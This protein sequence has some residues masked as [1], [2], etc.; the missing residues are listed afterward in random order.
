M[1]P[2]IWLAAVLL[3]I[4][5]CT[6]STL[7]DQEPTLGASK[8]AE[9]ETGSTG[10]VSGAREDARPGVNGPSALD[11]CIMRAGSFLWPL[12]MGPG[13]PP[14]GWGEAGVSYTSATAYTYFECHRLNATGLELGPARFL[15]EAHTNLPY[16]NCTANSRAFQMVPF[17]MYIEGPI[18]PV[19]V[20]EH[21][22]LEVTEVKFERDSREVG[23]AIVEVLRLAHMDGG[24]VLE[25]SYAF[26]QSQSY[27]GPEVEE[28]FW[29]HEGGIQ[30]WMLAFEAEA[31][32]PSTPV[33][34]GSFRTPTVLA[35]EGVFE[36]PL[37]TGF[38]SGISVSG[39]FRWM[40]L[41]EC[42]S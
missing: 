31:H 41:E 27:A 28:Y 15:L 3:A 25:L 16:N 30:S 12:G 19:H 13:E 2:M 6:G 8:P 14:D 10:L 35:A 22:G 39:E 34:H 23:G 9:S 4:A 21:W 11:D 37:A 20:R 17:R 33:A 32:R 40:P 36:G 24:L 5:G 7:P 42:L 29:E 18:L 1:Q 26:A 38:Y